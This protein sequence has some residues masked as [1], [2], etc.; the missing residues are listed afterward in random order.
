[1][2]VLFYGISKKS[3]VRDSGQ[4]RKIMVEYRLRKMN[5][6]RQNDTKYSRERGGEKNGSSR[7]FLCMV[8][9]RIYSVNTLYM[10]MGTVL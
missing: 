2:Y 9:S 8:F 6:F 1:M 7:C 3:I 5:Y 4:V 10:G